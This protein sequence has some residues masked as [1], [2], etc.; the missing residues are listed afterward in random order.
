MRLFLSLVIT[1]KRSIVP[2]FTDQKPLNIVLKF[3]IFEVNKNGS[4]PILH[5]T[6]KLLPDGNGVKLSIVQLLVNNDEL[7]KKLVVITGAVVNRKLLM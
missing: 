6:C 5:L 7:L 3:E 1:V 2:D 4:R